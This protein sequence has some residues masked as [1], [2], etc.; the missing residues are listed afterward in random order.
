MRSS[1]MFVFFASIFMPVLNSSCDIQGDDRGAD[2]EILSQLSAAASRIELRGT[3]PESYAARRE[4]YIDACLANQPGHKSNLVLQAYRGLP[5]NVAELQKKI[6]TVFANNGGSDFELSDLVRI[7]YLGPGYYEEAI[8]NAAAGFRFWLTKGDKNHVWWSENHAILFM[9]SHW[10]LSER[11]GW[12]GYDF[13]H[14]RTRLKQWLTLKTSYGYYEFYS[15]VYMPY[16]LAGVLNLADF[17]Q[18]QEIAALAKQAAQRLLRDLLMMTNDQGT[19]Y[20]VAGRDYWRVGLR[21]YGHNHNRLIY[22]L[23]GAGQESD[24][25]PSQGGVM[26]ATSSLDVSGVYTYWGVPMNTRIDLGHPLSSID[27]INASLTSDDKIIFHWNAGAYF[28]PDQAAS[29]KAL[30]DK[31][32]WWENGQF[33][34][35]KGFKGVSPALVGSLAGTMAPLVRGSVL[36]SAAVNIYKNGSTLL[37]SLEKWNQGRKGYQSIPWIATTGKNAVWTVSGR[38]RSLPGEG[39]GCE[40]NGLPYITQS[41]NVALM[42]YHAEAVVKAAGNAEVLLYWP[43]TGWDENIRSGKWNIGREGDSYL[44]VR[45]YTDQTTPGGDRWC[46]SDYQAWV[47]VVGNQATH[48]SFAAFVSMIQAASITNEMEWHGWTRKFASRLKVDGKSLWLIFP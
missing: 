7:L 37:T 6:D 40:N 2:F 41:G 18:D 43:S 9:S 30:V 34:E 13:E 32:D 22:L 26:L 46:D 44:A 21:A 10:L 1:H 27:S 42:Q 17:A 11:Y 29:S 16:S 48:G 5:L 12:R 36:A 25:S 47:V 38:G 23:T 24:I 39:D 14:L 4:H 35:Y 3:G 45:A 19:A 20:S 31:Y 33:A 8:K 15:K 28:S